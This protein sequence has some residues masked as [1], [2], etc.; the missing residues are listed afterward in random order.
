MARASAS[1][2]W[3]LRAENGWLVNG[4]LIVLEEAATANVSPSS[5]V[6]L[7]ETRAYGESVIR[8]CRWNAALT[9]ARHHSHLARSE[10]EPDPC[11][12]RN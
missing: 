7:L 9:Q 12:P 1:G 8:I 10:A 5:A 3:F 11:R 4:A 2:R 6:H